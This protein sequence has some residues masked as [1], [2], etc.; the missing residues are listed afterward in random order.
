MADDITGPMDHGSATPDRTGEA[1]HPSLRDTFTEIYASGV[2]TPAGET[3]SAR[4]PESSSG[5]GSNLTQTAALR[6]ALPALMTGLGVRTLLDIPCGDFFWMSQLDLG[7]ERYTGA[8]IVPGLIDRNRERFARTDREFRLIDLTRDPL[9]RVDLVF[10][11]DCL[12]HLGDD[13]IHRALDNIR[14]SGST[15]LATTTFTE[16]AENPDDIAAGG[17]RPLNLQRPP[18]ALPPP[19]RLINE[20]CTEIYVTEENGIRIEHRF[21]DKSI[22][23]WRIADLQATPR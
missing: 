4:H 6:A 13:D 16:R 15:Y 23:V 22:G 2:W 14:S 12:V 20:R 1:P 8:D 18:F 9:P 21:E 10:S 7:V 11:R 17:W 19:F 3:G 5:V